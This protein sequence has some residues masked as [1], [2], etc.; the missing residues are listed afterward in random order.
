MSHKKIMFPF[1]FIFALQDIILPQWRSAI[2]SF[3]TYFSEN[4]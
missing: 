1:A 3:D 2:G 4:I